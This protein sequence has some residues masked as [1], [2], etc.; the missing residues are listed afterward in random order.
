M[1]TLS[2]SVEPATVK[3]ALK[4]PRWNECGAMGTEHKALIANNTWDLVPP[5]EA[6]NIVGCRWVFQT[7][8]LPDGSVYKFISF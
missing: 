6:P 4:Y 2:D 1:V 7:K 5:E 8:Y 3:Q